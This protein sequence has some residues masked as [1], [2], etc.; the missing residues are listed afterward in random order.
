VYSRGLDGTGR[1]DDRQSTTRNCSCLVGRMCKQILQDHTQ[2]SHRGQ[3]TSLCELTG[4]SKENTG[5]KNY[6]DRGS[7]HGEICVS[8][9]ERDIVMDYANLGPVIYR[10][11]ALDG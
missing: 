7:E 5:T 11:V 3:E 8:M 10:I 2:H 6:S 9:A 4:F 1:L